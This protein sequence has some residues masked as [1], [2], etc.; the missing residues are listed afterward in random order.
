M[1]TILTHYRQFPQHS[2]SLKGLMFNPC[3]VAPK[4]LHK[5]CDETKCCVRNLAVYNVSSQSPQPC[6]PFFDWENTNYVWWDNTC[7]TNLPTPC[8]DA[9]KFDLYNIDPTQYP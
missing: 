7:P 1:D 4:L 6:A 8:F 2:D 9:C 5:V 3:G